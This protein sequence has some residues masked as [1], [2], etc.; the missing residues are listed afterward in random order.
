M[1]RRILIAG[2]AILT[3]LF[4]QNCDHPF[5]E[6]RLPSVVEEEAQVDSQIATDG[7]G[8]ET[9]NASTPQETES[10]DKNAPTMIYALHEIR[11]VETLVTRKVIKGVPT[12][13]Q[14]QVLRLKA[15]DMLSIHASKQLTEDNL[16]NTRA[17][18]SIRVN[19]V[20]RGTRAFQYVRRSTGHH[21]PLSVHANYAVRTDGVYAIELVAENSSSTSL[22]VDSEQ[23]GGTTI[24]VYRKYAGREGARARSAY[25]L[26]TALSAKSAGT[27]FKS[28][29]VGRPY[30]D[31]VVS[32][33]AVPMV[34]GDVVSF[35]SQGVHKFR[36]GGASAEMVVNRFELFDGRG[37]RLEKT[38]VGENVT[39]KLTLLTMSHSGV[40]TSSATTRAVL[41]F[42]IYGGNGTGFLF[43]ESASYLQALH[44][45]RR[46][47][48]SSSILVSQQLT[49]DTANRQMRNFAADSGQQ[50]LV[51]SDPVTLHAGGVLRVVSGFQVNSTSSATAV[52]QLRA[53]LLEIRNG[54]AAKVATSP[55]AQRV[56]NSIDKAAALS[57]TYVFK[58]PRDGRY[59]VEAL[60]Y[61]RGSATEFTYTSRR[62]GTY[63]MVDAF[64]L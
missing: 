59:R 64:D 45:S 54:V 27:G 39:S 12:V 62:A 16:I 57:Q 33:F 36:N 5:S 30:T 31:H 28:V 24:E 32:Q 55:F 10:T 15:G 29:A 22:T 50:V 4:N 43:S 41:K 1:A 47:D 17:A 21:M 13:I 35:H 18:L 2:L 6:A 23:Y 56:V 9:E 44:F 40:A 60:G 25:F 37:R 53:F 8:R 49:F 19:G 48:S 14:R 11:R 34:A 61:C 51:A 63:V 58:A 42:T 26:K 7:E 38:H 20:I 3:L 52:C 46:D